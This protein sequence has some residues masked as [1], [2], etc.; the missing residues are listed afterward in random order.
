LS[1]SSFSSTSSNSSVNTFTSTMPTILL[2]ESTTSY[3]KLTC[4][5]YR[6]RDWKCSNPLYH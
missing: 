5:I 2:S 6:S 4:I 3:K 1:T